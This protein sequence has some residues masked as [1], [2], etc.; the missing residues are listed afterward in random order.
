[1]K[2]YGHV[3]NGKVVNIVQF[4]DGKTFEPADGDFIDLADLDPIPSKGWGYDG[5]KF[6]EP[7]PEVEPEAPVEIDISVLT[8]KEFWRL[9]L[10]GLGYK[11]K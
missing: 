9:T 4:K 2:A 7:A 6:T 5:Q 10:E 3:I 8:E 11:V 1:M